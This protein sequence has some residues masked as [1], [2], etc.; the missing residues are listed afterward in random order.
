MVTGRR[1]FSNDGPRTCSDC[2]V[3]AAVQDE[4]EAV[5]PISVAYN[6]G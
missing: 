2:F 5:A 6:S 3:A 4:V 1:M